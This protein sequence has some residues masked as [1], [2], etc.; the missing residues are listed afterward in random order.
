MTGANTSS[1]LV[2]VAT[3]DHVIATWRSVMVLIFRV[4][5]TLGAVEASH[6]VFDELSRDHPE[7]VFLLTIVEAD[8]RIPSVVARDGM[9]DFLRGA[10]GRMSLSA[11]VFEG[12]NFRAAVVR[13]VV[14]GLAML[15]NYPFPHKHFPRV[16]GAAAWFRTNS[17][18]ANTWD[19]DEL[20]NVVEELR[21]SI[22]SGGI[23]EEV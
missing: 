7:G 10:T 21:A 22:A 15:T 11:V 19:E 4:E 3:R 14:A 9:A 17:S 13:S 16:D 12:N 23:L 6:R 5:T 18:L 1:A 20:T 2:R 8:A